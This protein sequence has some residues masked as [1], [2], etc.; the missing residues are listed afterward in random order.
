MYCP[1]R[2][3]EPYKR[4]TEV[5]RST[6]STMRLV[7]IIC[8]SAGFSSVLGQHPMLTCPGGDS[9]SCN[10][11]AGTSEPY[12]GSHGCY[13]SGN[14]MFMK[15][16]RC[17]GGGR[18]QRPALLNLLGGNRAGREL[19]VMNQVFEC[20]GNNRLT[21]CSCPNGLAEAP[22]PALCLDRSNNQAVFGKKCD[23]RDG[24]DPTVRRNAN[25]GSYGNLA[26]PRCDNGDLAQCACPNSNAIDIGMACIDSA[27]TRRVMRRICTCNGREVATRPRFSSGQRGSGGLG[28]FGRQA[29]ETAS[30]AFQ[31]VFGG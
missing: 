18:P 30:K 26:T 23:C 20:P 7:A 19:E 29:I 11:P 10:C 6:Q 14:F 2:R 16:C 25:Q 21:S 15:D 31:S 5:H 9:P 22:V 4:R 27:S 12:S 1:D 17:A 3:N 24:S 8:L 28:D 13:D